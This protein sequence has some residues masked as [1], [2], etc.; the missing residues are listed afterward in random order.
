MAEVLGLSA[1][2]EAE[3]ERRV[4]AA[5]AQRTATS[6]DP[7]ANGGSTRYTPGTGTAT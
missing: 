4:R 2:E 3:V 7:I 6:G 5:G 1:A